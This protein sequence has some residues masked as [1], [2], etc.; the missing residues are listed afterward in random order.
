MLK[1]NPTSQPPRKT[2]R[3]SRWFIAALILV[4]ILFVIRSLAPQT[5]GE[6]IRRKIVAQLQSHYPD[7]IVSIRRGNFDPNTGLIL[8]GLRIEEPRTKLSVGSRNLVTIDRLTVIGSFD[9]ERLKRQQNPIQTNRVVIEG[10]TA[11]AWL[12]ENGDLSLQSLL[13]L[14]VLGPAAPRMDLRDVT[15]Q[16]HGN[17]NASRPI[18]ANFNDIVILNRTGA[19]GKI[20]RDI[21]INGN[22]DFADQIVANIITAGGATDVRASANGVRFSQRLFDQLPVQWSSN[23]RDIQSL[24]CVFDTQ[25]SIFQTAQGHLNYRVSASVHDGQFNHPAIPYPVSGLRGKLVCDPGGVTIQASQAQLGDA[26]VSVVGNT[27]GY[28]IPCDVDLKVATRGLML[29]NR[30]AAALPP[31][32]Q[33]GWSKIQPVGRIDFDANVKCR[34]KV[35]ST[36][37]D[38]IC[39]GVDVRYEKFPYPVEQLVGRIKLRDNMVTTDD[40]SG[41]IAGNRMQCLFSMPI[42]PEITH[43]K[44]FAIATDG[45][46]PIDRVLLRSL[47]PRGSTSAS[48]MESFVRSLKPSG[49]VR[50]ASAMFS[51]DANNVKTR[52]VDLRV[53]DGRITYDKFAYPLYNVT[54][55]IKVENDTVQLQGF[56]ATNANAGVIE[57]GGVYHLPSLVNATS[58]TG[59]SPSFHQFDSN[60]EPQLALHFQATSVPM[61][62]SLRQSL[63]PSTR[64]VWDTISP[65]GVL[66]QLDVTVTK[67]DALT[68][69]G[70]DVTARQFDNG[71]LTNRAL[72]L[73]PSSI[74]YR[75]DITGGTVHFDGSRVQ[76][77]S[78]QGRHDASTLSADGTCVEGEDGRWIL[79]LDLH[80]GSRLHPDAELV[81][82]LPGAMRDAMRSLQLRGPVSVRGNT[83]IMLPSEYLP[84]TEVDWDLTLQ[85]EGN[86]IGDVGPVHSLRGEVLVKGH[87]DETAL[88]AD[89][90][91]HLD[92]IHVY[93]LQITGIRG[94][95]SIVNDRLTLGDRESRQSIRG[96]IFGG[97]I[98]LDG[99]AILSSGNFDVGL[100]ITDAELPTMLAEFGFTGQDVTGLFSGQSQLQGN[101]STTDL[102][103]GTGATRV[104]GANLYEL[105]FLVKVFNLLRISPSEDYAFTDG[106]MEFTL[107]GDTV[108][109]SEMQ[110]WGDLVFAT[111]R[112]DFRSPK[113]IGSYLQYSRKS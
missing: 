54:G 91:V 69:L 36:E 26:F 111:R 70:L 102:L 5:I 10:V 8:E 33:K 62:E 23:F 19:D 32:L 85:L 78:I 48:G 89:G 34:D 53:I 4:A 87:R 29:D 106:E 108:T 35:W 75:L 13:P 51:T 12:D 67:T 42:R 20:E 27:A 58:R 83:Q 68:P 110:I 16:L 61:D 86:R 101:L 71:Q 1:A 31:N 94:P 9:A 64:Q 41:R 25:V 11:N 43:E 7:H 44:S 39:K 100:S 95:F 105:P 45:P 55:T 107:F 46:V 24:R 21:K 97:T 28:Q 109:F 65:S 84:S 52:H 99:G 63:P 92:S 40:L 30:V 74:P 3:T 112:R 57:C 80:S 66:D 49:S 22:A 79:A 81:A 2:S 88:Q 103:K 93:D 6:T 98:D 59:P 73:K 77:H 50:L 38:L 76:I 60:T 72:S 18:R 96:K 17:Q 104:S 90:R 14:P 82:S 37:A 47:S 15:L 56:R 113:R